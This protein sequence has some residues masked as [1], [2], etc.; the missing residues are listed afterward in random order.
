MWRVCV[1]ALLLLATP[2]WA[3]ESATAY[4][5]LR[6]VG[7]QFGRGALHQIVSV[8]GTMGEPQPE[9]WKIIL[10]DPEGR[11][12]RKLEIVNGKI[13]SDDRA[14]PNVAGSTEGAA[15]DVSSLNLDSS[16]AYAV[17]SHTA[18]ASHINFA[19]AD[20][21]LR[22][23]DRGEPTWIVTLRTRSSRPVGTIYIGATGGTVRRTEG[24]FSGATMEDVEGDY[25]QGDGRGVIPNTKR[26][27][28]HAFHR[29]QEE[30]RGV[31]ERVKRSFLDFINRE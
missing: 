2:V 20:Y 29:A 6:V 19:T 22:T 14:D 1:V 23:D 26:K 18:E 15:I 11:G 12:V 24:M 21:T 9:K 5:A 7:T 8:T 27:I 13:D 10:E 31:F 30:A 16:G 28:K 17:A 4:E 3:E 25:D